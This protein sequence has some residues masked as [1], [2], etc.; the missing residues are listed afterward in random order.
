[1]APPCLLFW[2]ALVMPK[3]FG[4]A[5][6]VTLTLAGT[7]GGFRRAVSLADGRFFAIEGFEGSGNKNR[8]IKLFEAQTG[9][10]RWSRAVKNHEAMSMLCV[11][12]T[13]EMLGY[14]DQET[15]TMVL[16]E[17]P[18][19]KHVDLLQVQPE[20]LGPRARS[21]ARSHIPDKSGPALG[22]VF[23]PRGHNG[24]VVRLGIDHDVSSVKT[25]FSSDGRYL[26]WGDPD[27]SVLVCNIPEVQ[28][29]FTEVKLGWE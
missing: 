14:A 25:L 19:G 3:S 11:D 21:W 18:G 6:P 23:N 26:A 9:K 8:S 13:G 5:S 28:R 7:K 10:V 16:L 15:G 12:S 20:A 22:M 24:P 2:T 1:M 29:R 17:M 27:G 4:S